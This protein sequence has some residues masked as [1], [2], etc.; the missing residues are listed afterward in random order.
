M[1][2][3]RQINLFTMH[4][5]LPH[6]LEDIIAAHRTEQPEQASYPK[7]FED[8]M[9]EAERW[10]EGE[11]H[12]HT[13]GYYCGLKA[14]SFPPPEQLTKKEMQIVMKAFHHMMFTWNNSADFP[15]TLPV[16]MAY[17]MLVNTLNEKTFIP[18]HGFAG[19]DY[20]TG[21]APGCIYKEYCPCL[22]I[23]NK[24]VDKNTNKTNAENDAFPF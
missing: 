12:P 9:E 16:A 8:E 10:V 22:E 4:P 6:L 7:T 21:Y 2:K 11:D 24:P 3:K 14:E 5:Y 17:S 20:C 1:Y 13:F 18:D 23:W 19:F 15:T